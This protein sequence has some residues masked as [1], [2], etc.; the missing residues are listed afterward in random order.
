ALRHLSNTSPMAGYRAA[1]DSA[2]GPEYLDR[3]LIADQTY[4]LP[5]G[6]LMK[7]DAMSMANSVEIRVPFLDRRIMEF[8]ARCSLGLLT[9]LRGPTKPVLR[10]ALRRKGADAAICNAPKRGFNNPL[11]ELLRGALRPLCK[12]IFGRSREVF[13]PYLEPNAV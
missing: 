5:S 3:C 6:L 11:A 1:I 10:N 9:P 2:D 13:E 12:D 8:S 4:H 7:T